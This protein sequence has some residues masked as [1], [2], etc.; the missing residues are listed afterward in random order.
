VVLDRRGSWFEVLTES[1]FRELELLLGESV[2][3]PSQEPELEPNSADADELC[4][5][6]GVEEAVTVRWVGEG[7]EKKFSLVDVARLVSGKDARHAAEDVK[8]V[9]G[10]YEVLTDGVGQ[11]RFPGSG[12]YPTPMADLRTTLLVALRLRSRVAQLFSAKVADVFVR[13]LGGDPE[14]ATGP[15]PYSP[16]RLRPLRTRSS[17]PL[18]GRTGRTPRWGGAEQGCC[19]QPPS[20]TVPAAGLPVCAGPAARSP[21]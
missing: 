18:G 6:L 13:Y 4:A 5:L 9:L 1:V 19:S 3:P 21:K 15:R 20:G 17:P 8:A 7:R 16:E 10:A 2:E 12:R 14:L 11:N